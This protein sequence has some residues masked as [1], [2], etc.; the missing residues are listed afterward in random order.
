MTPVTRTMLPE[1]GHCF[2]MEKCYNNHDTNSHI[3]I[4]S[5][6]SFLSPFGKKQIASRPASAVRSQASGRHF[7]DA[8]RNVR[9]MNAL[10]DTIGR[11]ED[12]G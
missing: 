5:M 12:R 9:R 8:R 3:H 11:T 10:M 4:P 7:V 6:L 2:F 1:W